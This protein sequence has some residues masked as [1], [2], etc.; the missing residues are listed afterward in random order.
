M[1]LQSFFGGILYFVFNMPGSCPS[2]SLVS[3]ISRFVFN[4][5][6]LSYLDLKLIHTFCMVNATKNLFDQRY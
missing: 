4:V 3:I 5:S 2:N 1:F 6:W